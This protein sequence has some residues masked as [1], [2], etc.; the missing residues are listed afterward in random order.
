MTGR[1]VHEDLSAD[2]DRLVRGEAPAE[3][4]R[5]GDPEYG[6]LLGTARLQI[7]RAHV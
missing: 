7:G 6:A 4:G 2:I 5:G 1:R 3:R